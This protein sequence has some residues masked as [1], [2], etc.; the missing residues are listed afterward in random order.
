MHLSVHVYFEH[1]S[2][3]IN[4]QIYNS[5]QEFVFESEIISAFDVF[6]GIIE[7]FLKYIHFP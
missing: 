4:M 1:I 5:G 7:N 2:L 3:T 6:I